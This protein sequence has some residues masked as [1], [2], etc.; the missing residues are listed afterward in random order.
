M[1]EKNVAEVRESINRAC[2]RSGRNYKEIQLIAVTKTVP[3]ERILEAAR[4][5]IT[6]IGE[7]RV[8]ES[9][10]KFQAVNQA[11]RLKWHMIGSLQTNKANR[12]VEIFDCIQSLD[13][14]RCAEAVNRRASQLGKTQECLAEI[15]VS[16]ETTKAGILEEELEDFLGRCRSLEHI[17][18]GGMMVMAPYTD[19]VEETRPY[20]ARAR[21]IFEKA[22]ADKAFSRTGDPVLSM[23]MSRD[24]V[25]A[26]EE[27]STMVRVG[28]GIFGERATPQK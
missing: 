24:F 3:A 19:N 8:Q 6:E 7:S 10:D 15:K 21:K 18:V 23:G 4:C 2:R 27:G 26:I 5:G 1:I 11:A 12:A 28:Q 17:R 13:N 16:S 14:L 22:S 20:F 9:Q 25:I